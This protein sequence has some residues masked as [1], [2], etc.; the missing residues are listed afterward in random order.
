MTALHPAKEAAGK[1]AA[2]LIEPG[3]LIGIGTG[4]TAACF[5][6]ALIERV[7]EGLRISAVATSNASAERAAA[8]GIAMRDINDITSVDLTVDGADEI[9]RSMEMIKGGGGALLREKIVASMSD[10]M[11]V[12]IDSSKEVAQ[13]GAAPLPIEIIP[14]AFRAT[15]HHIEKAGFKGKLRHYQEGGIYITDNGN[16]IFDIAFDEP[17]VNVQAID[18][19]LKQIAGVVETGLFFN[20][21]SQVIVGFSDGHTE[22]RT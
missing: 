20:L 19:R 17:I 3:M 22:I 21:A 15:L 5:I 14:F 12:I 4:T 16:Y 8:G 2:A 9:N 7:Q 11:T 6:D 10:S 18:E 1:A 13:L